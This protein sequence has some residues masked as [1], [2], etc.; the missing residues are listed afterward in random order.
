MVKIPWP[1]ANL[2]GTTPEWRRIAAQ[3]L[4]FLLA[5]REGLQHGNCEMVLKERPKCL[6][7]LP[8]TST[9]EGPW[10]ARMYNTTMER[11]MDRL[12]SNRSRGR[13]NAPAVRNELLPDMQP[14]REKIPLQRP[15][16]SGLG[17]A[18]GWQEPKE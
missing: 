5:G 14:R 7:D 9:G 15:G 3:A 12:W 17:A 2:R 11:A 4:A 16:T 8:D 10:I 6:L 18:R 13:T 1:L